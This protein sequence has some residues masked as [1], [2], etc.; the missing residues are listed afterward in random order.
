M[1]IGTVSKNLYNKVSFMNSQ[2]PV[3]NHPDSYPNNRFN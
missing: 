1:N 3:F 2:S